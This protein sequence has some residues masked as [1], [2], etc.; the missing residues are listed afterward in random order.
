MSLKGQVVLGLKWTTLSTL[1]V[2]VVA[3]IKISVLARFLEKSDFG[4]MALIS[5]VIG[6]TNLFSDMGLST[7]ILHKQNISKKTYASLFWFNLVFS[8]LLYLVLFICSPII[9][10]FYENPELGH[11]ISILGINL[12]LSG[13]GI[14]FKTIEIK[15]LLFKN[16]GIVEIIAAL[17][18]LV[19]AIYLA[20]KNY[21]VLSLVYSALVQYVI[22]N[23]LYFC[24]GIRKYGLL[25]H[26]NFSETIPFLKIGSYQV[27]GQVANYFNRDLDILLIGK[28][29]SPEILGGYSLAKQLVFRPAQVINP[30]LVKVASP[31]LAKFQDNILE[32]KNNYLK[33]IRI[34]SMINIPVYLTIIIF[35]PIVVQ[36][37][38]GSG[39]DNIVS[40]VRILS[41]YMIFRALGNPI[42]SLVIATGRT[43]LEFKWNILNLLIMPVFIYV[44][45]SFG[46]NGVAFALTTAMTLLFVPNWK[47][48]VNKMTN[49][50]LIEYVR[51]IGTFN[52]KD[53]KR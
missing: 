46:I 4:L 30:I 40:I 13:I 7:A 47:Y 21:G 45:S 44:G 48:L 15:N 25:F 9:G 18:S 51:A 2:A 23:L 49:A 3:V 5:F 24:I 16:I 19:V 14:Q 33:L 34:V 36:I 27:G 8:V 1:V 53:L 29:F 39:F 28:F 6:F 38:Y 41:I 50:S 17:I 22:S 35:A 52:W 12:V 26:F 10:E 31:T 32:L 20:I 11:L 43:D 37:F 42:G